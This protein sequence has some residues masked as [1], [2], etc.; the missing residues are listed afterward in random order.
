MSARKRRRLNS[1]DRSNLVGYL[2][3]GMSVPEIAK[4]ISWDAST[5]YRE[6]ARKPQHKEGNIEGKCDLRPGRFYVCN[7]CPKHKNCRFDKIYYNSKAAEE[8]AQR[9]KRESHSGP[10]VSTAVRDMVSRIVASGTAN[11]QSLEHI[12]H[13]NDELHCVSC[14]TIRRWVS[15]GWLETTRTQLRRARRYSKKYA[16]TGK[17]GG[18]PDIL[19]TGRTYSDYLEH[20][21]GREDF[22]LLELDSV[23]G[24]KTSRK[25][26]FTL[27]FVKQGFQIARLYDVRNAAASVLRETE[28]I[29]SCILKHTDA[30][31]IL[32]SDN[33]TEFATLPF[34]ERL[35]ERVRVFFTN[36]YRSTDK[37]HCE[38]NHEYF[39]YVCPKGYSFDGWTQ[40]DIDEIFSNING[41]ARKELEWKSPY[42]LFAEAY[43]EE[44]AEALGIRGISP[45]NVNLATKF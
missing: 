9:K 31:L 30:E 23:E 12:Y 38:R 29:V 25:R 13:F 5:I 39:R 22:I 41:Y 40:E 37:A 34:A 15:G 20:I 2:T 33:G 10:R 21:D 1:D 24:A 44:A 6:I 35:S 27:M 42:E 45:R 8:D 32:L 3:A 4:R 26:L 18:C 7:Q 43:S 14:I 28:E 36:P 19:K 11:G 16:K 17:K